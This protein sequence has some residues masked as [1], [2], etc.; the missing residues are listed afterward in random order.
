MAINL[1]KIPES[2]KADLIG[3]AEYTEAQIESWDDRECF[4]KWLNWHGIIGYTSSIISA[5]KAIEYA[6]SCD[7][8]EW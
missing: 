1:N 6:S 5:V 8:Q 4:D 2:M 7:V 3:G